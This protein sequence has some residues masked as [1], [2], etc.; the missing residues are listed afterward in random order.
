MRPASFIFNWISNIN[1]LSF[2][3]PFMSSSLPSKLSGV[4]LKAFRARYIIHL[5]ESHAGN[6]R[7]P[8]KL[9]RK[10]CKRFTRR[11]SWL[12][13]CSARR[14]LISPHILRTFGDES[15]AMLQTAWKTCVP[16]LRRSAAVVL[17]CGEVATAAEQQRRGA[18]CFFFSISSIFDRYIKQQVNH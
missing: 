14:L 11:A 2:T 8:T 13:F 9:R 7:D 6:Q 1:L 5:A 17:Q 15:A 18:G 16:I 10:S 4:A 12:I 3:G